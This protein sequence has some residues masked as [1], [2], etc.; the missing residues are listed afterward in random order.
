MSILHSRTP[1]YQG[2]S[3]SPDREPQGASFCEWFVSLTRTSTP[4]YQRAPEVE[5]TGFDFCKWLAAWFGT[6]TPPY[7]QPIDVRKR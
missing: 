5:P 4:P 1:S 6:E 7:Q 2:A 3:S